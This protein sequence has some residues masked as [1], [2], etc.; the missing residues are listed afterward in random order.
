LHIGNGRG[1]AKAVL[2]SKPGI[3]LI[4]IDQDE[5]ALERAEKSVEGL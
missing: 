3:R 2:A 5:E 4:G 1:I